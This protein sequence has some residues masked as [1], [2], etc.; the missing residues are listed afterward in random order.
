M[1]RLWALIKFAVFYLDLVLAKPV[2]SE[3][4]YNYGREEYNED[5]G[6]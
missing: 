6:V 1:L 5:Q 4:F 3:D 2:S